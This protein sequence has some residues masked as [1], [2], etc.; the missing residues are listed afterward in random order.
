MTHQEADLLVGFLV[1]VLG[2]E[3]RPTRAPAPTGEGEPVHHAGHNCPDCGT[4]ETYCEVGMPFTDHV[5]KC[6]ECGRRWQ[7]GPGGELIA[8][9]D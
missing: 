7:H 3:P 2:L 4:R 6:P 8:K 9:G 1:R 5:H